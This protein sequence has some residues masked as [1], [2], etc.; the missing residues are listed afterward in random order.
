MEKVSKKKVREHTYSKYRPKW[1]QHP[2]F[3]SINYCWGLA[4]AVD[5]NKTKE[6]LKNKCRGCDLSKYWD[7]ER[8]WKKESS[9]V[10]RVGKVD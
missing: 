8:T 4:V 10:K 7:K 2:P 1:C 5:E 3:E 6:F 9:S